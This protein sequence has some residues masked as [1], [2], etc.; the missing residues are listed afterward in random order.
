MPRD[1]TVNEERECGEARK[2]FGKP[3]ASNQAISIRRWSRAPHTEAEI[4][5]QPDRETA[6]EQINQ[7]SKPE[8]ALKVPTRSRCAKLPGEPASVGSR[9]N[10]AIQVHST[11]GCS[12][13][14][15]VGRLVFQHSQHYRIA[16]GIRGS[17]R[18]PPHHTIGASDFQRQRASR[19]IEALD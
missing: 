17:P 3:L 11:I 15:A 6:C 16:G 7:M 18:D 12:Q 4:I 14:V 10:H 2:P 19:G 8:V 1:L 5:P 9:T 13:D